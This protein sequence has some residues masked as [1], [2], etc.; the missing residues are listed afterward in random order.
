[1]PR[2]LRI[3]YEGAWYHVMNRGANRQK[4]FKT[5]QQRKAFLSLLEEIT[6][7]FLAEIHAYCLMDNHYHLLIR[8]Q[9]A[10]LGRCMRHLDGVYT[11]K[12]NRSEKRDGSLFRG[13]YKS[14]LIE[15]NVYLLQVSRYIHLN[16][17]K[18]KLCKTPEQYE[19][20]S[21]KYYST[22]EEQNIPEQ[23][24]WLKTNFTLNFFGN[25][26]SKMQYVNFINEGI[27]IDTNNFYSKKRLPSI[28]GTKE[29]INDKI[30][31]I[32]E[33]Q[34]KE[35]SPDVNILKNIPTIEMIINI[36]SNYF[37]SEVQNIKKRTTTKKNIARIIAIYL[38]RK[39][40]QLTHHKIS[41]NFSLRHKSIGTTLKRFEKEII[42][43][44]YL[45]N[46]INNLKT[47]IFKEMSNVNT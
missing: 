17:I 43:N 21:F 19:W 23:Y 10:N 28:L 3:E 45:Q 26:E 2:P 29:F 9:L 37:N 32:N 11:Q 46:H 4:I 24:K 42:K 14:I 35:S 5:I 40:G 39:I 15:E 12:F 20:S 41:E 47:I 8:T 36:V 44:D 27:D 38:A 6:D 7:N 30:S 34:K 25:N 16:P 22:L 33:N 13:R 1:M 18:A 31:E